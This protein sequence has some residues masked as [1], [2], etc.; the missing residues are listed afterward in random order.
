MKRSLII[1]ASIF[2]AIYVAAYRVLP[3]RDAGLFRNAGVF[4]HT[5]DFGRDWQ[6]RV[7]YPAAYCES[8]LIRAYPQP[9]LPHPSWSEHRQVLLLKGY[10]WRATFPR[11]AFRG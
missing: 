3:W 5:R 1:G 9:W 10:D 6:G 8:L 2:L 11:D 4:V 7:F